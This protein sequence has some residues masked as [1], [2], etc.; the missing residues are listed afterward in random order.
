MITL[1][2]D[3]EGESIFT[4]TAAAPSMGM[5]GGVTKEG[6]AA[7][8]AAEMSTLRKR[9]TE[10]EDTVTRMKVNLM[11]IQYNAKQCMTIS[12][13]TSTEWRKPMKMMLTLRL[14][15]NSIV[16]TMAV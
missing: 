11:C 10:L 13:I 2:K 9:V 5:T 6:N 12:P 1:Y 16:K 14:N 4:T 3:P 7:E 15:C 8:D